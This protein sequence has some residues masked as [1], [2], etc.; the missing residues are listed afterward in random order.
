M[1]EYRKESP[2]GLRSLITSKTKP[3]IHFLDAQDRLWWHCTHG[4]W[5]YGFYYRPGYYLKEPV[6][7]LGGKKYSLSGLKELLDPPEIIEKV[8]GTLL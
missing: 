2:T 4:V 3:P 7:N 5:L 6:Y 1:I 8:G